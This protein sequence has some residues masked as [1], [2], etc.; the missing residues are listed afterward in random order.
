MHLCV[1]AEMQDGSKYV[2]EILTQLAEEGCFDLK[3]AK[4]YYA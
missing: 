2:I 1:S 3:K 4:F